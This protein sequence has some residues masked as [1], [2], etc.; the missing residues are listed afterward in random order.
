VLP[1]PLRPR[2]VLRHVEHEPEGHFVDQQVRGPWRTWRHQHDL[3]AD[4]EG[5]A[6]H[7]SIELE[8]PRH[9]ERLAPL[10]EAAVTASN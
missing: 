6:I 10:A 1:D 4:G 3:R 9:L 5:T 8:L 7:D 2:W